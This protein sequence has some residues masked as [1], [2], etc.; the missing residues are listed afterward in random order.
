LDKPH[1]G[2]AAWIG[3]GM[4]LDYIA[5]QIR[6]FAHREFPIFDGFQAAVAWLMKRL[7]SH[8]YEGFD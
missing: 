2:K 8:I 3:G 1:I 7:T 6:E 5:A 4:T